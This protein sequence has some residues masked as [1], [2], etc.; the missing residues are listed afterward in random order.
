MP[1]PITGPGFTRARKV[2]L[3]PGSFR[4]QDA[5]A[6]NAEGAPH[7]PI[8]GVEHVRGG[9]VTVEAHRSRHSALS[10]LWWGSGPT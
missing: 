9:S 3:Y 1:F 6:E 10:Y 7:G 8:G 4:T 5:F 2:G